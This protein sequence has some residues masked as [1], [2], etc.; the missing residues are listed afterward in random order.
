MRN[1]NLLFVINTVLLHKHIWY[2]FQSI[3]SNISVAAVKFLVNFFF[4]SSVLCY[5]AF[6]SLYKFHCLKQLYWLLLSL[7][8]WKFQ[9]LLHSLLVHFLRSSFFSKF[10]SFFIQVSIFCSNYFAGQILSAPSKTEQVYWNWEL[11]LSGHWRMNLFNFFFK[12]KYGLQY[13]KAITQMLHLHIKHM[14]QSKIMPY[15]FKI[16]I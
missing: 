16:N 4:L 12:I 9:G 10:R 7:L 5:E 11:K 1:E 8:P 15:E 13:T 6:F 14:I 3:I 2:C